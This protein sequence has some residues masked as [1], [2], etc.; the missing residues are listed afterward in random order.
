MKY[1]LIVLVVLCVGCTSSLECDEEVHQLY[2]GE[3][4]EV[5]ETS[6]API[7][8]VIGGEFAVECV[9]AATTR[10]QRV[11]WKPWKESW[12]SRLYEGSPEYQRKC[13]PKKPAE[14]AP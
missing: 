2:P 6:E 8:Y 11:S 3:E 14:K 12:C 9:P 10:I 7:I 13:V 5:I 4:I 1:F